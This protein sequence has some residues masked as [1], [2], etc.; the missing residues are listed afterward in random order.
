MTLYSIFRGWVGVGVGKKGK[1]HVLEICVEVDSLWIVMYS[2]LCWMS[3][4]I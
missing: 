1:Y 3:V 4:V 2:N